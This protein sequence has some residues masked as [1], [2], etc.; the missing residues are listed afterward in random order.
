MAIGSIRKIEEELSHQDSELPSNFKRIASQ[1]CGVLAANSIKFTTSTFHGFHIM[2]IAELHKKDSEIDITL[3]QL[4]WL[5]SLDFLVPIGSISTAFI[6]QRVGSRLVMLW[7][8]ILY[9]TIWLSYSYSTSTTML[10]T[11]QILYSL[12]RGALKTPTSTYVTEIS[13]PRLRGSFLAT[14][15]LASTFGTFFSLLM[16]SL[17][18]WRT[19]A[20][21]NIAFPIVSFIVI[22][23]IPDSPMWLASQGRLDEAEDALCWLRGWARTAVHVRSEYQSL[24][25]SFNRSSFFST[26]AHDESSEQNSRKLERLRAKLKPYSQRSFYL[27]LASVSLIYFIHFFSGVSAIQVYSMLIFREMDSPIH[28]SVATTSMGAMRIIGALVVFLCIR[29]SGKRRLVFG[30]LLVAGGCHLVISGVGFLL[31]HLPPQISPESTPY[32]WVSPIAMIIAVFANSS[33]V[34]TIVHMLNCEIFPLSIR[35]I[36]SAI[37]G[38]VGSVMQSIMSKAFL[39]MLDG[40]TLPGLFLYFGLMNGVAMIAYYFVFPETEGRSLKEIEEHYGGIKSLT[41]DDG[42]NE[43]REKNI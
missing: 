4:T 28:V 33:G 9:V 14:C 11:A 6:T 17:L 43:R 8:S 7:C 36:G 29:L 20:L 37:G 10:M 31:Q 38:S 22:L 21:I 13:E 26:V 39:Y 42:R 23:A 40:L 1:C 16:G 12:T 15:H 30:S 35:Y 19:V 32:P 2:L 25:E 3:N 24:V 34:E 5:A 41:D 27:P 18:Y